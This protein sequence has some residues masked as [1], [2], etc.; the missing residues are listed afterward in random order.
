MEEKEL[1]IVE[2]EYDTFNI[3]QNF[4]KK[5]NYIIKNKEF[6]DKIIVSFLTPLNTHI[7]YETVFLG[8]VK[9]IKK[10]VVIERKEI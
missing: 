8:K 5:S 7:D 2:S 1:H 4:L 6:N 3:L 9:E 10:E